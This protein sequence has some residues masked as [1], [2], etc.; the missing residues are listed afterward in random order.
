MTVRLD[1]G[2]A[3]TATAPAIWEAPPPCIRIKELPPPQLQSRDPPS[4]L[5]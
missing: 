2:A 4:L 1:R 3:A 5:N